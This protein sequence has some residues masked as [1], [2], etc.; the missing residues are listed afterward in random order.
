MQLTQ[1]GAGILFGVRLKRARAAPAPRPLLAWRG[2]TLD[3]MPV[4]A[5]LHA[6][7][8]ETGM[9]LNIHTMSHENKLS[10]TLKASQPGQL[11]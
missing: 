2:V 10:I 9:E 5:A 7:Y 3:T 8:W 11:Y 6:G 4:H 1:C